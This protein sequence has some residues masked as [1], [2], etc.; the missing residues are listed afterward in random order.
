MTYFSSPHQHQHSF[1]M[2]EAQATSSA[3]GPS[4]APIEKRKVGALILDAG[5]LISQTPLGGLADTYWM[6]TSVHSELKDPAARA[7]LES[8]QLRQDFDLSLIQPSP[9]ALAAVTDF[10]RKTGDLAVLSRPD[11]EVLALA[12]QKETEKHGTWRIRT[13]VGGK[14]GQQKHE[15]KRKQE[16]AAAAAAAPGQ[17]KENTDAEFQEAPEAS[18]EAVQSS[19]DADKELA[20]QL[21]QKA[22]IQPKQQE[23]PTAAQTDAK[24]ATTS[25]STEQKD[26]A[27]T[28]EADAYDVDDDSE[29]EWITPANIQYHKNLSLGLIADESKFV[30]ASRHK[31]QGQ[32]V[33]PEVEEAEPGWETVT[34]GKASKARSAAAAVPSGRRGLS[35]SS[36]AK[37]PWHLTVACMTGDFAVQNVL[38]QMGIALVGINGQRINKVKSYVLRCHA[39]GKLCKD[40]EKKWCPSCGN[41]TLLRTSVSVDA[42]DKDGMKVHLKPNFQYRNR[43]TLFSIPLPKPGAASGGKTAG[44]NIILRE[45]QLEWQRAMARE[46]NRKHKEERARLRAAEKGKDSLSVR[47]EEAWDTGDMF[48]YGNGKAY[49]RSM[50]PDIGAGRKNPNERRKFRK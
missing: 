46:K 13:E 26:A 16:K 50:L 40:V 36:K 49:D 27:Q 11:L 28:A 47:Y 19:K 5:A 12:Y 25:T 24:P 38:L 30:A 34:S 8:L 42:K 3:A 39:C 7:Y 32:A 17:D 21:S 43:G 20:Q 45:D 48:L 9:E 10:A 18:V 1:I 22:S 14:T 6:P 33:L 37:T 2:T 23:E 44:S 4:S 29:G 41:A 31:N 15:L 35:A